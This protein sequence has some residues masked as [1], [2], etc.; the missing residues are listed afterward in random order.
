[1]KKPLEKQRAIDLRKQGLSYSEILQSIDV[2]K[3]T[4]SLWLR[5][6]G[7]AKRHRQRLTEKKLASIKR[8]LEKWHKIRVD[9]TANLKEKAKSEIRSISERELWL[10]GIAL[11]WAEGSKERIAS[12][13][14]P[15][16][17]S[18]SDPLMIKIFLKWLREIVKITEE[19]I[20]YEI[21]I[22]ENS[23]NNLVNVRNFWAKVANIGL[24]KLNKIYFKK[25][26]LSN[27]RKRSFDN[28]FGLMRVRVRRS[29][30][31]NRTIAGWVEGIVEN[32]GVV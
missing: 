4:L 11:Y 1:M 22:H 25:N 15:T 21:Y 32:C 17:F 24:E 13:G 3:S 29:S 9:F 23:K 20:V 10:I 16:I 2:S 12:V 5:S 31:L 8:G 6:V 14:H 28:Y 30:T 19:E 27:N 26:K 18:N 7:L